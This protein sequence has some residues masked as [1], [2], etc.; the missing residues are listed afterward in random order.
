MNPPPLQAMNHIMANI[1]LAGYF[2]MLWWTC[3]SQIHPKANWGPWHHI[4]KIA[5]AFCD[6]S[7]SWIPGIF[8][9]CVC[10]MHCRRRFFFGKNGVPCFF[11]TYYDPVEVFL[12]AAG[13]FSTGEQWLTN[14]FGYSC[15]GRGLTKA[16]SLKELAFT[17]GSGFGQGQFVMQPIIPQ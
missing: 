7:R 8:M 11:V 16:H 9:P 6:I 17:N 14:G 10:V 2:V 12:R 5:R 15:D 4:T 13:A 3:W 1:W